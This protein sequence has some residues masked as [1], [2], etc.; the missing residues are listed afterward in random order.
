MPLSGNW[1]A[2]L[3]VAGVPVRSSLQLKCS[4]PPKSRWSRSSGLQAFLQN[5]IMEYL[6]FFLQALQNSSIGTC[7]PFSLK[8]QFLNYR[9]RPIWCVT[10]RCTCWSAS[11]S[12]SVRVA[13]VARV[14]VS[15][16]NMNVLSLPHQNSA[17]MEDF[18][19]RMEMVRQLFHGAQKIH[20]GQWIS[21]H[22]ERGCGQWPVSRHSAGRTGAE[23]GIPQDHVFLET[24]MWDD[25]QSLS[26]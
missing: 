6:F 21:V 8:L 2:A 20:P 9:W 23:G 17:V 13:R 15:A 11:N 16:R 25:Y 10:L 14:K 5:F 12:S 22:C 24:G 3:E 1:Q 26:I 18:P 7:K 19:T 4:E